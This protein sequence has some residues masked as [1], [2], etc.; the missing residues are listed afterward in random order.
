MPS[1]LVTLIVVLVVRA[2]V[3]LIA[4]QQVAQLDTS[5]PGGCLCDTPFLLPRLSAARRAQ[6]WFTRCIASS[7]ALAAWRCRGYQICYIAP[8]LASAIGDIR[9]LLEKQ[10]AV[11]SSPTAAA[12]VAATAAA[13]TVALSMVARLAARSAQ[14]DAINDSSFGRGTDLLVT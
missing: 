6:S 9:Q 12:A 10:L 3:K 4:L 1:P 7:A 8:N 2:F 5:L 14:R 13:A 11:F